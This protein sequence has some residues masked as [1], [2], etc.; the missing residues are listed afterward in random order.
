MYIPSHCILS[1]FSLLIS[2][3]LAPVGPIYLF[4]FDLSLS[5]WCSLA[6]FVPT[7]AGSGVPT[8][9]YVCIPPMGAGCI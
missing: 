9:V 4:S 5:S 3:A 7:R 1:S 6:L 8:L 2:V